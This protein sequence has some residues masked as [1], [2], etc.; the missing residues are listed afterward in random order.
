MDISN[1]L[2]ERTRQDFSQAFLNDMHLRTF[3]WGH[4]PR[5]YIGKYCGYNFPTALREFYGRAI[6]S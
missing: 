1:T 6:T 2:R 4:D 5:N 3:E